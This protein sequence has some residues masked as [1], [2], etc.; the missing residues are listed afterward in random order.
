[1]LNLPTITEKDYRAAE[2]MVAFGLSGNPPAE[3]A[4]ELRIVW[5]EIQ[6]K[7]A[8]QSNQAFRQKASNMLSSFKKMLHSIN[9]SKEDKQWFA[10]ELE[11]MEADLNIEV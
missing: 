7:Y 9:T 6:Q 2:Q 4:E 1:M 3:I 8:I 5:E 10:S 11:A